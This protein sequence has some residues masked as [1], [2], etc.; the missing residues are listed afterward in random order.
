MGERLEL[1]TDFAQLRAGMIVV[2]KSCPWCGGAHR[3]MLIRR[4]DGRTLLRDLSVLEQK[5]FDSLPRR[6]CIPARCEF[7]SVSEASVNDRKV[8]KVIDGLEASG[9]QTR[10]SQLETTR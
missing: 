3:R 10:S 2:S 1:V 6:E 8:F 7:D 9:S 4:G 5:Y